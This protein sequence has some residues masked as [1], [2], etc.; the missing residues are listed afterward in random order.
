[1]TAYISSPFSEKQ[2]IIGPKQHPGW[3]LSFSASQLSHWLIHSSRLDVLTKREAARRPLRLNQEDRASVFMAAL[4][5]AKAERQNKS[6]AEARSQS[7][8]PNRKDSD[9]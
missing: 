7:Q 5:Q 1:M 6:E 9:F 2:P 3:I 8:K 4:K